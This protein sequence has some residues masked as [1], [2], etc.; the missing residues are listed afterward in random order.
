MEQKGPAA[1]EYLTLKEAAIMTET[2]YA[3]LRRDIDHGRLKAF[4]VGRKYLIPREAAAAYGKERAVLNKV[5]GYT[6][7]ELMEILPL[8]YAYLMELIKKGDLAAVKKGRRYV[9]P[10]EALDRFM[11]QI[12]I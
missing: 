10:K 2:A 9:I 8:S 12:R 1:G 4:K 11:E 7:R 6:I 5:E 3:T